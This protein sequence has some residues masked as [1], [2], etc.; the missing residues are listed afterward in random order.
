M[1]KMLKT[2]LIMQNFHSEKLQLIV[3][4]MRHSVVSCK[5]LTENFRGLQWQEYSDRSLIRISE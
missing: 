2:L 3:Q 5:Q 1:F 4:F